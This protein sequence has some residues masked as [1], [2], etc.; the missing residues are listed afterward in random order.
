MKLLI[1]WSLKVCVLLLMMGGLLFVHSFVSRLADQVTEKRNEL[2]QKPAEQ[3]RIATLR[4][5][6]SRR[7][8]DLDRI[9]GYVVSRDRIIDVVSAIEAE[10]QRFGVTV[11]VPDIQE[12]PVF[13]AD[14]N[15]IDPTG[16]LQDVEIKVIAV[17]PPQQLVA[18]LH[19]IDHLPYILS[20]VR[21]NLSLDR[22]ALSSSSTIPVPSGEGETAALEGVLETD[23]ILAVGIDI[24]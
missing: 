17:G 8:F 16:P 12:V 9:K 7:A 21:W 22:S 23:I 20:T 19:S 4:S 3:L 24:L 1:A 15:Q 6:L 18:F 13:D 10:G 2:E 5:E 14:G 11:Q